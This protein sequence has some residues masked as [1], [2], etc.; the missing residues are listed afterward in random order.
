[1]DILRGID[2]QLLLFIAI[3]ANSFDLFATAVGIH[4]FGNREGNPL[5]APLVQHSWIAFVAVKGILVPLL[6]WR[7]YRYRRHTPHLST[8]GLGLVTVALTVAV[9]AWLGW[10][11]GTLHVH[12]IPR[13]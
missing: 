13:L 3:V 4:W 11:A 10:I 6:I 2:M 1:L 8:A 12:G 5:L 9:G 7:L